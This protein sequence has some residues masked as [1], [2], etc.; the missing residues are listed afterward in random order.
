MSKLTTERLEELANAT[1]PSVKY[2]GREII[3]MA[4]QLLAYEQAAKNPIGSFHIS[5]GQV[6]A[7]TDYCRDGEWPVQD[8]EVLVYAAPVLPKQ[9]EHSRQHF[10]SLC[11]QFWNWAELDEIDQDEEPRLEWNGSNYTHRV[12]AALWKM[13]QAAPAQPVIPEGLLQAINRLLDNDGSRGRFSAIQSYDA[14]EDLERLLAST[15]L[16]VIPEQPEPTISFYR[17][18]IIAAAKWVENQRD[19]YD[20]EHGQ[21]DPDTG[22]FEFGN[23]AQLEYSTTLSE[24][25]EGIRSLHSVSAQPVSDPYKLPDERAKYRVIIEGFSNS[26]TVDFEACSQEEAEEIGRDIFHEECNYGVE[27]LESIPAQESE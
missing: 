22:A 3:A 24:I 6:E 4:R 20:N 11:N 13:Y 9:P 8:G 19:A 10:E 12:T 26:R 17:D 2:V 14:R 23:N 27:R 25:A 18:G 15:A 1:T 5:G 7:T 16:P 21:S